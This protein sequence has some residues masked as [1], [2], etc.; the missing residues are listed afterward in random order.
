[1]YI[2][3][4]CTVSLITL[5]RSW[6]GLAPTTAPPA[7]LRSRG[8]FVAWRLPSAVM[9]LWRGNSR[10]LRVT[11]ITPPA[12]LPC[13]TTIA[14]LKAEQTMLNNERQDIYRSKT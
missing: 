11:S 1:L 13:I 4:F 14:D 9:A 6:A 10:R 5:H 8:L 2:A 3:A 12:L 7:F